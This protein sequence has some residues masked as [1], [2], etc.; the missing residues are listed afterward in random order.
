VN[1][2]NLEREYPLAFSSRHKRIV[3]LDFRARPILNKAK[4]EGEKTAMDSKLT[5]TVAATLA[6]ISFVLGLLYP[7]SL[8][9]FAP[10]AIPGSHD[11]LHAA[12][13]IQLTGAVGPESLAFDP[14]GE[15]PYTGVA[16]G[17][18]LKWQ[19]DARGWT[20]FAFTTSARYTTLTT[21]D[22]RNC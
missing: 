7:G 11:Q 17:R 20:D 18:I 5:L 22:G 12:E 21:S 8:N 16:D 4:T 15:G 6:F 2:S 9:P 1:L 10:R 13:I 14:N 19:G 3:R